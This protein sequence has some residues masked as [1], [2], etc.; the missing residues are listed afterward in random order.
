MNIK[1]VKKGQSLVESVVTLGVVI[2]LVTGL[3]VGTTSA[4]KY[5]QSS[6]ARSIATQYAAEGLELARRERDSGWGAF[7]RAGTFCVGSSGTISSEPCD[8]LDAVY[9]RT[10]TYTLD[11]ADDPQMVTVVSS[12]T[13]VEGAE[14]KILSLQTTL[15]NWK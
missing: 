3:V 1:R 15:T 12:V 7:A 4:L 8:A 14:N 13:W 11:N 6:R 9:S 5:A 10:L 2:L